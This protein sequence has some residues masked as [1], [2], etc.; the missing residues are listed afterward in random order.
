MALLGCPREHMV[1]R[2]TWRR[3]R[4][5][6]NPARILT[7]E[8]ERSEPDRQIADMN[9]ACLSA[10]ARSSGLW[11]QIVGVEGFSFLPNMQSDGGDL[12]CQGQPRQLGLHSLYQKVFVERAKGSVTA[13]GGGRRTLKQVLQIVVVV[14]VQAANEHRLFSALQLAVH[15]LIV[16]AAARLQAPARSRPRTAA[17]CGSGGA[18]A[19]AR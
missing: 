16:G 8:P 4:T 11:L 6:P 13:T 9:P 2:E 5:Q 7:L 17:C 18:S 3:R 14:Q 12:A 1:P 15:H 19:P 10:P